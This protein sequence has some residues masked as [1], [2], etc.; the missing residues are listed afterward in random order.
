MQYSFSFKVLG[1]HESKRYNEKIFSTGFSHYPK[2][3]CYYEMLHKLK[4]RKV[5]KLLPLIY[6]GN[7][8]GIP[9]PKKTSVR[10]F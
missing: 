1:R 10:L 3:E 4:Q 7:F 5:E 2:V 8:F 9:R 6:M